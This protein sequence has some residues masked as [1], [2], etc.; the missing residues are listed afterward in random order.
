M[1]SFPQKNSAKQEYFMTKN[2]QDKWV[3]KAATKANRDF[4]RI[5]FWHVKFCSPF[6]KFGCPYL[7]FSVHSL[8]Q[9]GFF[10]PDLGLYFEAWTLCYTLMFAIHLNIWRMHSHLIGSLLT[11]EYGLKNL[12]YCSAGIAQF[13]W[14]KVYLPQTLQTITTLVRKGQKAQ[15]ERDSW[16]ELATNVARVRIAWRKCLLSYLSHR[17]FVCIEAPIPES[18][19]RTWT[20]EALCTRNPKPKRAN[21]TYHCKETAMSIAGSPQIGTVYTFLQFFWQVLLK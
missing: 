8:L 10:F 5:V 16:A 9:Q 12:R 17:C 2:S 13:L 19:T 18:T 11:N 6:P 20:A 7:L 15:N 21:N 14:T 3:V 4:L 1:P